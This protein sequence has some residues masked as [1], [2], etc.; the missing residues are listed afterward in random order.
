MSS[1]AES[2]PS[3]LAHTCTETGLSRDAANEQIVS[4]VLRT[5]IG[6]GISTGSSRSR[7][8]QSASSV[9]CAQAQSIKSAASQDLPTRQNVPMHHLV[10][11]DKP[12]AGRDDC[13]MIS[14]EPIGGSQ[15]GNASS[16]CMLPSELLQQ[17]VRSM[18]STLEVHPSAFGGFTVRE[19]YIAKTVSAMGLTADQTRSLPTE[20]ELQLVPAI[21]HTRL[22][23]V[24]HLQ[25]EHAKYTAILSCC[26]PRCCRRKQDRSGQAKLQRRAQ[27]GQ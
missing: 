2:R 17:G 4:Q 24:Q 27:H 23:A 16:P 9:A 25:P 12:S 20:G 15:H 5:K 10:L 1:A 7:L 6:P 19:D 13:I 8:L 18:G 3:A 14:A 11:S 22:H 21:T 26:R